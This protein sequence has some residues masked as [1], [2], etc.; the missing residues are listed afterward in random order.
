[1]A[2]LT[3]T[4]TEL[5]WSEGDTAS[6]DQS[7]TVSA[8][9]AVR[10]TIDVAEA[11]IA[12]VAV[13]QPAVV[14][15]TAGTESPGAVSAIGLLPSSSSGSAVAYPVTIVV[16]QTGNGLAEG[17]TAGAVVTVGSAPDAV[18]VPLSALTLTGP[19]TGTV[20]VLGPGNTTSTVQ[21]GLG[22]RGATHVEV[23]GGIDAGATLVLA[24]ITQAIPTSTSSVRIRSGSALTGS[25]GGGGRTGGPPR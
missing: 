10:F 7:A 25:S 3:G 4:L 2:P 5:P 18:V 12:T 19:A 15:S 21:V 8:G 16:Q 23:T 24:D 14:T 1:M 9:E 22:V 6:A 13:G 20:T 17:T 11:S